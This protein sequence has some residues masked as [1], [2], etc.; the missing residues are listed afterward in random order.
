LN[1]VICVVL[2]GW[3]DDDKWYVGIWKEAV[4]TFVNIL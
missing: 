1:G 2:F 3:S 4:V